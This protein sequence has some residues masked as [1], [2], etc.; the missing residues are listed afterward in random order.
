[1]A[2]YGAGTIT[3]PAT[4][5]TKTQIGQ[6]VRAD[7]TTETRACPAPGTI[8]MTAATLATAS[9]PGSAH[10]GSAVITRLYGGG[11]PGA[12]KA[13][14]TATGP[15]VLKLT[16]VPAAPRIR[17][18]VVKGGS[19]SDKVV[20]T[21]G[22]GGVVVQATGALAQGLEAEQTSPG[23]LV[24]AQCQAPGTDFWFVGPG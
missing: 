20:T 7:V 15:N 1:A 5:G 14:S 9:L 16:H 6:Q 24:T 17:N 4:V 12:G 22:R 23:G 10:Q 8:G 19:T 11:N 18:R 3:H 2:A 21:M 13:E